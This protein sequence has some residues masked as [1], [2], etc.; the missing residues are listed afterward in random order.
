VVV[1]MP[2]SPSAGEVKFDPAK[3]IL[4]EKNYISTIAKLFTPSNPTKIAY[5]QLISFLSAF[6]TSRDLIDASSLVA[7]ESAD[8][9][10]VV[11]DLRHEPYCGLGNAT[12]Y[13]TI[14]N[15][16]TNVFKIDYGSVLSTKLLAVVLGA[17]TS[18][19]S[20]PYT[21]YVAISS[22]DVAYTDVGSG[23]GSQT[24]ETYSVVLAISRSFRYLKFDLLCGGGGGVNVYLRARKVLIWK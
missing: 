11:D 13:T 8:L 1:E 22:D 15:T 17:Y 19:A 3:T 21:W 10:H 5:N 2:Y 20:C 6:R 16:R 12:S 7:F 23:S 18:N 9:V 24:S 4:F 14:N